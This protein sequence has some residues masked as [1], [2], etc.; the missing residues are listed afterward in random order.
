MT[1]TARVLGL[2]LGIVFAVWCG[3][4]SAQDDFEVSEPPPP[5][6]SDNAA[7]ELPPEPKD[8]P[9]PTQAPPTTAFPV[10]I[11][12][13]APPTVVEGAACLFAHTEGVSPGAADSVARVICDEIRSRGVTIGTPTRQATG[14]AAYRIDISELSSKVIVTVAYHAP[15]GVVQRSRRV[16]ISSLDEIVVAGPRLAEA[17]VKDVPIED[18]ER[19]DNVL[20]EDA[21][22]SVKKRGR[23]RVALGLN[24]VV[25]PA[26]GSFGPG[27]AGELLYDTNS[28]TI[29]A[30][31]NFASLKGDADTGAYLAIRI[32]GRYFLGPG[33]FAP[34]IGGGASLSTMS[35]GQDD[36]SDPEL[37][38]GGAGV[39]GEVG[40]EMLRT[41]RTRLALGARI[42][43]PFFGLEDE[44]TALSY[45]DSS[46]SEYVRNRGNTTW[47]PP[48]TFTATI[49]F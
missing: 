38:G 28:F 32:G 43:V 49:G 26:N 16:V 23:T 20:T 9:A 21:K 48:I 19:V 27:L 42:D 33:D 10:E 37:Q 8:R 14:A 22:R 4:A 41:H 12:D 46:T 45:Y 36:Y 7:P 17:I 29:G 6:G 34:Y 3:P 1:R 13:K 15:I 30:M 11:E 35:S 24:T 2:G 44:S 40:F 25:L 18:T 47:T 31:A 5:N 39:Y